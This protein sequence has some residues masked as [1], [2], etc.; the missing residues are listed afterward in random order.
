MSEVRR[1]SDLPPEQRVDGWPPHRGPFHNRCCAAVSHYGRDDLFHQCVNGRGDNAEFCH[2]HGGNVRPPHLSTPRKPKR[3]ALRPSDLR[4]HADL[5]QWL[6]A[7]LQEKHPSFL[8]T[9]Y[10]E[11]KCRPERTLA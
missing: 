11:Y 9:H 10:R 8:M 2:K 4:Y 6:F 5:G 7:H 1:F 3:P